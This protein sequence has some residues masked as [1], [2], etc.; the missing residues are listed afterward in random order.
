[1]IRARTS[2]SSG[3]KRRQALCW[4]GTGT[5]RLIYGQQLVRQPTAN[6]SLLAV[7]AKSASNSATSNLPRGAARVPAIVNMETY[8]L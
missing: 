7:L 2:G 6:T 3:D 4:Q 5:N 1:M 8:Q